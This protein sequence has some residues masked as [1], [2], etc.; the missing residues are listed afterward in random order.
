MASSAVWEFF[1]KTEEGGECNSC[2]KLIKVKYSNTTNLRAHLECS[3]KEIHEKLL[4]QE[5]CRKEKEGKKPAVD[6]TPKITA[7][8]GVKKY[9]RNRDKQQK[10]NKLVSKFIVETCSPYC[11]VDYGS[12]QELISYL[13]PRCDLPS[14]KSF[15]T[16]IIPKMYDQLELKLKSIIGK[17]L[18][19]GCS[20]TFD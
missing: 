12:F 5:Q 3:H 4:A 15:R 7:F 6:K 8:V 9:D 11:I 1:S 10:I 13:D 16:I 19:A 2:H 14:E 20:L 17:E 18:D